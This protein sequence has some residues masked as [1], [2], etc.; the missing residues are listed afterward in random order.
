MARLTVEDLIDRGPDFLRDF[1]RRPHDAEEFAPEFSWLLLAD[2]VG[3][4]AGV[5]RDTDPAMASKWAGI[6]AVLYDDLVRSCRAQDEL[7]SEIWTRAAAR[8]RGQ[9]VGSVPPTGV[10]PDASEPHPI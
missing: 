9:V 4:E 1:I 2:T 6:A 10:S 7:A 8:Y 3:F 5:A